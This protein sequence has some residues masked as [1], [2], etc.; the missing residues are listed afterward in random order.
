MVTKLIPRQSTTI[1]KH[2]TQV[3]KTKKQY[4]GKIIPSM[5][6]P[7]EILFGRKVYVVFNAI[8]TFDTRNHVFLYYAS[9]YNKKT[10]SIDFHSE[11][12]SNDVIFSITGFIEYIN[13][14]WTDKDYACTL[15][16]SYKPES[17]KP[18]INITEYRNTKVEV[19]T[20]HL[21]NDQVEVKKINPRVRTTNRQIKDISKYKHAY[22]T[23]EIDRESLHGKKTSTPSK[24]GIR[25][26]RK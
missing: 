21:K 1:K 10:S 11:R 5:L 3:I 19:I 6:L 18:T 7:M 17:P 14:F 8:S 2:E 23:V 9:K 25:P 24:V 12:N 22:K 15:R 13:K 16:V 4:T 26:T 20:A